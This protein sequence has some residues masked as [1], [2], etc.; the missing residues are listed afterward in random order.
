MKPRF[1]I[2]ALSATSQNDRVLSIASQ[3]NE[4]LTNIGIKVL[5]DK[6]LSKNWGKS[7]LLVKI[8]VKNRIIKISK[9]AINCDKNTEVKII[10]F[11]LLVLVNLD[12]CKVSTTIFLIFFN[13]FIINT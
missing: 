11:L 7:K 1:S 12:T 9:Y 8:F 6:N 10:I 4:V 13:I 5:I 3:C 2:V